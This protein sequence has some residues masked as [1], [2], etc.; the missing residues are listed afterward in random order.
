[1]QDI[2]MVSEM[3]YPDKTSTAYIISKIADRLSQSTNLTVIAGNRYYNGEKIDSNILP[4]SYPI[5]RIR[6][7]SLDKNKI[8]SRSFK[9]VS[10]SIKFFMKLLSESTAQSEVIIVT[11]P[12]PFLI[13]ASILKRIKGFKLN[14]IVQDVFPENASAAGIIS[15]KSI[16]YKFLRK[17]WERSFSNADR[18]IVCGRDMKDIFMKKLKSYK[19][20]PEIV[21]IENWADKN[22]AEIY[23]SKQKDTPI[24][25]L[26]AGNI[27]R[28]QGIE[29][30]LNLIKDGD[31][32]DISFRFR[33]DGAVVPYLKEF[34]KNNSKLNIRYEGRYSRDEQFSI[35]E[36]CD[37]G[38]VTLSDDMYGLG[39][40]SKTYNIMAA[41]KPILFIGDNNSEIARVVKEYEVGY[42]FEPKEK[43][44][45]INW[46]KSINSTNREEFREKGLKA[47]A[48][49]TSLYSEDTILDKYSN[50]FID[51]IDN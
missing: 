33:G 17:I 11:N 27:G 3:F 15:S 36:Q 45:I 50:L 4:K 21:V 7:D 8:L 40:P 13:L 26:F 28:C 35:L 48:I 20:I 18:L 44:D 12:A 39:V 38:L 9:M 22:S 19:T 10:T 6:L 47:L 49:A 5:I 23:K 24:E 34:I 51:N 30:F 29:A 25:V 2:I 42:S 43:L 46:F 37:I 41:G 14:I 1:M 16:I 32:T 31:V